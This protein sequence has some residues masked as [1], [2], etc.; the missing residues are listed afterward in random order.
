MKQVRY[1][2]RIC[3]GDYYRPQLSAV[4]IFLHCAE[5]H[6]HDFPSLCHAPIFNITHEPSR[7]SKS[8]WRKWKLGKVLERCRGRRRSQ[9]RR[10]QWEW[11]WRRWRYS[12]YLRLEYCADKDSLTTWTVG[13]LDEYPDDTDVSTATDDPQ[14]SHHW[15]VYPDRK[16]MRYIAVSPISLNLVWS[17]SSN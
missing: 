4:F 16:S 10:R 8:S 11:S 14:Y 15:H 5:A 3:Q 7:Q 13:L 9:Q 6:R 17:D 1:C 12:L 2:K